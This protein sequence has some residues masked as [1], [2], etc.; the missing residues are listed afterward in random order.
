[1]DEEQTFWILFFASNPTLWI[2]EVLADCRAA[3]ERCKAL[4][5]IGR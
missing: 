1:M 5:F 2:Y 3:H 4:A